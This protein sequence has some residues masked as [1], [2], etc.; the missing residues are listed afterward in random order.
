MIKSILPL[1]SIIALRFLGLFLVLPVISAYAINLE[2]ATTTLVGVVVGGY[3]LTQMIF[4]VPFG[5]ISDKL[6]R[7]G[8]IVIGLILFIIGSLICALSNDIWTLV[9][10]RFLQGAGAIGA[11]VTAM[12]SDLVPE[13]K[14]PKDVVITFKR[15][16]QC[17]NLYDATQLVSFII[18]SYVLVSYKDTIIRALR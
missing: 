12:I 8:T 17:S 11:V 3:A 5:V 16:T 14:R 15:C 4:Q 1:S 18:F 7:K 9:L 13:E 2:G 6:G 10:G